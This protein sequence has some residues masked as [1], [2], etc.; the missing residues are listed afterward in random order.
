MNMS[1]DKEIRQRLARYIAGEISLD[2]FSDWFQPVMWDIENTGN[3]T[4]INLAYQV[5]L[6]LAE[7]SNGDWT[8]TELKNLLRPLAVPS[9]VK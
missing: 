6:C 8:E 7:A 3:S 2:Q 1:P 9:L 5:E 4:A